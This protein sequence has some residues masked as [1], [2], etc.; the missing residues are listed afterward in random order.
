MITGQIASNLL[1]NVSQYFR[2]KIY[3]LAQIFF[4]FDRRD[5]LVYDIQAVLHVKAKKKFIGAISTIWVTLKHVIN[6]FFYSLFK[7]R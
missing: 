3:S 7:I 5:K 4:I 2:D 6:V 1:L